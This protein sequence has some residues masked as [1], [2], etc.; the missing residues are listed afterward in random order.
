MF[1]VNMHYIMVY[2]STCMSVSLLYS[3]VFE[4][5]RD[6]WRQEVNRDEMGIWH[7]FKACLI[8]RKSKGKAQE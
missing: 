1:C 5:S 4:A 8:H 3:M 6:P 2:M 7:R